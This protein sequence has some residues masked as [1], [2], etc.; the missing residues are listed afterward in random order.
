MKATQKTFAG[1]AAR[2]ARECRI[3]YFCGADEAGASDA[4]RRIASLLPLDSERVELAGAE[5]KRDPARLADEARS[6]SLFGGGDRYI[7]IRTAGDECAEAV[8]GLLESPVEPCPVLIVA[9]S[10]TDK[11]RVAKLLGDR[12]DALVAVFHPP[13]VGSVKAAVR[14]MGDAAGVRLDG[15]LAERIAKSCGLDTRT[16]RSEIDKLALYLD[17]SPQ[18]PRTADAAAL[19]A[20]AA[21]SEDDSFMPLVNCVL[22]G[23]VKRLPGEL[24]RLHEMS[25]NPVGLLLACERRA[26]Q[27]GQLGGRLGSRGD[28]ESFLQTERVFFRDIPDL[29]RQL[30]CWRGARLERLIA[31]LVSLHR[32]LLTRSHEAELLLAQ[33][34]GEIART[35]AK[36]PAG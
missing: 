30:R 31:R 4:A 33:G 13:D 14:G 5:L 35:A 15:A 22:S 9:T 27:L 19:D 12:E 23:E 25:L 16:A 17:A 36:Q 34:L 7:E 3:F 20:I 8:E 26:A 2:A 18:A 1:S 24:A 11:S 10:A 28:V 21:V 32:T 6:T 29:A